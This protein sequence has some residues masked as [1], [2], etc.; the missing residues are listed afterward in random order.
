MELC[1]RY[2]V[3]RGPLPD[4][5]DGGAGFPV[6]GKTLLDMAAD[7]YSDPATAQQSKQ[8]MRILLNHHLGGKILHTRELIKELQKL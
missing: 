7:E 4:D 6:L 1:Y 8:L 2:V 5:G 3:E